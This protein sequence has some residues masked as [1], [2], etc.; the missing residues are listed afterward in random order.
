MRFRRLWKTWKRRSLLVNSTGLMEALGEPMRRMARLLNSWTQSAD[1]VWE[2]PH[3]FIRSGELFKLPNIGRMNY[4]ALRDGRIVVKYRALDSIWRDG[5]EASGMVN[6]RE[7]VTR[8]C[9]TANELGGRSRASAWRAVSENL[10]MAA[11]LTDLSADTDLQNSTMMCGL[12]AEYED[13][14]SQLTEKH[15]AGVIVTTLV[16]TAYEAAV[17]A[18][19]GVQHK[20][21]PWGALGRD[22]ILATVG[23]QDFPHLRRTVLSAIAIAQAPPQFTSPEAKQALNEGAWA[24]LG[25]EHMRQFRNAM[26]HGS[27]GKPE[28]RDWGEHSEYIIDQDP[29][30]MQFEANIRLLLLLIQILALQD[31]DPEETLSGWRSDADQ[32]HVLLTQLHCVVRESD[33]YCLAFDDAPVRTLDD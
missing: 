14:N 13:V 20:R 7:H 6:L 21:R 9:L 23:T 12:A 8:L 18:V 30:I 5:D 24:A 17:E 16:W 4:D 1:P 26:I 28:P 27:I 31:V 10:M 2:A 11:S 33:Q 15:L 22:T 25:A 29:A 3:Q 19:A 32:A